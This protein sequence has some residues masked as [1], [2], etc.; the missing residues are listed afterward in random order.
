MGNLNQVKGLPVL[1]RLWYHECCRVFEDRLVNDEDRNWF[2]EMV[3]SKID[4]FGVQ[5]AEV[6][7]QVRY[8]TDI[9]NVLWT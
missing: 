8:V 2:Q 5:K 9:Q 3:I 6:I 4:T 1:L 7:N